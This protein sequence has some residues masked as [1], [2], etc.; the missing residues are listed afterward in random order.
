MLSLYT[1]PKSRAVLILG[2]DVGANNLTAKVDAATAFGNLTRLK[3]S[4]LSYL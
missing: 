1:R 4:R 3:L 2:S